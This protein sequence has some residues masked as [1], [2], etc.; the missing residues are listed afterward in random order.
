MFIVTILSHTPI[1]VWVL[2]AFLI[3][4]GVAAMSPREVSANRMLII[5]VVFLVWGL[6]GMFGGDGLAYKLALF[7]GGVLAG[8]ACGRALASLLPAPRLSRTTGLLAMP[9]SPMPLILI[10]LAFA[11]K[12]I[13]TVAL[14]LNPDL[15]VHAEISAAMA[16][17]GG[18]F[19]G[20]FWGRTL[21]Q[22][23][24]A[25][26]ADGEPVT[27]RGLVDLVTARSSPSAPGAA[28]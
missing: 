26:Q 1:W 14:A 27:L 25:L 9:G 12:Y 10:G 24:R 11:T 19:A 23:A 4:R 22:F 5:P 28:P 15:V 20:L 16:A 17:V 3:S 8:L 18:L 6:T 7:A 13:G 2:L 21:G